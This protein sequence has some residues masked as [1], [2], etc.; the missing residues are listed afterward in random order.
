MNIVPGLLLD[1]KIKQSELQKSTCGASLYLRNSKCLYIHI[2]Q[3]RGLG[4][5]VDSG[6]VISDLFY[7]L[8]IFCSSY[9]ADL[10]IFAL[11]IYSGF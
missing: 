8:I 7:F 4:H 5:G 6:V 2:C 11:H 1:G 10:F 9:F 3:E